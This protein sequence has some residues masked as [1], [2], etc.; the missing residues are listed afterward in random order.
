MDFL[1]SM[2]TT[3]PAHFILLHCRYAEHIIHALSMISGKT[4]LVANIQNKQSSYP[5]RGG[6]PARCWAG[7]DNSSP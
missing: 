6:P 5:K 2:R 1:A 3:C 4:K 7:V